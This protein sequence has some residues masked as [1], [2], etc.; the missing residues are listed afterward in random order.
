MPVDIVHDPEKGIAVLIDAERAEPLG[1]VAQGPNAAD[2]L[3]QFVGSMQEDPTTLPRMMLGA[4]W[5]AF[6]STFAEPAASSPAP[7]AAPAEQAG[8][9]PEAAAPVAAATEPAPASAPEPPEPAPATVEQVAQSPASAAGGPPEHAPPSAGYQVSEQELAG[10]PAPDPT[11]AG[12]DSG[13]GSP[14]ASE[15]PSEPSP[16]TPANPPEA[17]A[18]TTDA[19]P[20]PTQG[21]PCF[22]CGGTGRERVGDVE[23]TCP[24]CR[25]SRVF[26]PPDDYPA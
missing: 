3:E 18:A 23:Q 7:P 4:M 10:A 13:P 26:P 12:T 8:A 19:A 15:P 20:A 22:N 2:E 25:G 21:A 11:P 6:L 17:G 5:F 1:P 14:A 16:E 9:G 24:V